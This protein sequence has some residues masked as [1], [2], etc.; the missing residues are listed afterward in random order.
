MMHIG[1]KNPTEAEQSMIDSV[2]AYSSWR[3]AT[4]QDLTDATLIAY[5]QSRYPVSHACRDVVCC[6][7]VAAITVSITITATTAFH[8]LSTQQMQRQAAT[9]S[10]S[11]T[12]ATA[13]TTKSAS[14]TSNSKPRNPTCHFVIPQYQH[15]SKPTVRLTNHT[16]DHPSNPHPSLPNPACS[17]KRP[18]PRLW[19]GRGSHITE[20]SMDMWCDVR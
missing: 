9:S 15:A 19:F 10:P 2:T 4:G 20:M 18:D 11:A 14:N 17:R 7:V 16:P 12:I 8:A 5:A 13:I 6:A 3:N 1:W